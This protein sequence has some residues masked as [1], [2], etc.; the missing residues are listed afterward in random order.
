[1]ADGLWMV[2]FSSSTTSFVCLFL[3][4]LSEWHVLIRSF[5][6][7]LRYRWR[8]EQDSR[9][10]GP[11]LYQKRELCLAFWSFSALCSIWFTWTSMEGFLKTD[12]FDNLSVSYTTNYLIFVQYLW[13]L[14]RMAHRVFGSGSVSSFM[15]GSCQVPTSQ[16]GLWFDFWINTLTLKSECEQ[17][18]SIWELR[19]SRSPA[20]EYGLIFLPNRYLHGM[21]LFVATCNVRTRFGHMISI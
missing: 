9:W 19:R 14:L 1:M 6:S 17:E 13:V 5:F 2:R 16:S 15:S 18:E 8:W 21:T 20:C 11:R 3:L 12:C 4:I 7:I 10:R